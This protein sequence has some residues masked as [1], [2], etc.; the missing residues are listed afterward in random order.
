MR[1]PG[2]P[3]TPASTCGWVP[4]LLLLLAAVGG[5]LYPLVGL[6]L[7]AAVLVA[8]DRV[9]PGRGAPREAELSAR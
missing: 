1:Q 6:A 9:E 5:P 3:S 8:L 2:G 7:A 4:R